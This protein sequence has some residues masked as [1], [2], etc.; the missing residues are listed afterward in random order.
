LQLVQAKEGPFSWR[1][2]MMLKM[3][4][5]AVDVVIAQATSCCSRSKLRMNGLNMVGSEKVQEKMWKGQDKEAFRWTKDYAGNR[6]FC[7]FY[8]WWL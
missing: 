1:R 8:Y 3:L 6:I 4:G 7:C 2:L 5:L